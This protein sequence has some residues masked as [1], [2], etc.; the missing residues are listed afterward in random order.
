MDGLE[1][2][3][4]NLSNQLKSLEALIRVQAKSPLDFVF[5]DEGAALLGISLQT[6]RNRLSLMQRAKDGRLTSREKS[7][8]ERPE[9]KLFPEPDGELRNGKKARPFWKVRTLQTY[10]DSLNEGEF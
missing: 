1:A 7:Q 10:R 3:L 4:E 5:A 8:A 6:F 2:Q 9:I